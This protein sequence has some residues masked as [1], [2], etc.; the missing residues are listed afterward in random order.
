[1]NGRLRTHLTA[2]LGVLLLTGCGGLPSPLEPAPPALAPID[3][4]T[5]AGTIRLV[6]AQIVTGTFPTGCGKPTMFCN[7]PRFGAK[8]L[9]THYAPAEGSDWS[10]VTAWYNGLSRPTG[11]SPKPTIAV[12]DGAPLPYALSGM[13]SNRDVYLVAEIP[14]AAQKIVL[15]WPDG[16]PID[17]TPHLPA[18]KPTPTAGPA[19]GVFE[20]KVT[21]SRNRGPIAGAT[22]RLMDASYGAPPG[23]V[24]GEATSGEDGTYRFAEL[25][26][27]SY[28]ASA[29]AMCTAT[30]FGVAIAT[31][32]TV[33]S[34]AKASQDLEINC[35]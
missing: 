30:N 17:L 6:K 9:T 21:R 1:M 29:S 35:P 13:E 34:G 7:A 33:G 25:H 12:D 14:L 26:A 22:V 11:G 2:L 10:V 5:P 23:T 4:Q 32:Q 24:V 28:L 15:L 8:Y 31:H 20:G 27:G 3:L 16:P 19:T 18:P